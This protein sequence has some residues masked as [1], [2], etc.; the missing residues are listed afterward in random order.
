MRFS[1]VTPSF[2]SGKWLRSCIP[3]V[4]DQGSDVLLEHIVQDACSDDETAAFLPGDSR[5]TAIIE[6]DRGM[7]DAVNRGY[8]RAK[9][10]FLA[11]LNC[12]EQ[13]LPGAL[14]KVA[15]F[16][17]AH[18]TVD[19]VFADTLVVGKTGEYVCYRRA[20]PPRIAQSWIG[21]SL[22]ILTAATFVRRGVF[23][24]RGLWFDE[25]L[26]DIA[27]VVW[28]REVLRARVEMAVLRD[29]TSVFT[30]TGDNMNLKPNAQREKAELLASAPAWMRAG[31]P[32]ILAHNRLRRIWH[33]AY[34]CTPHDYAIYTAENPA[35]RTTFQ[36][37]APTP[38]WVHRE[39]NDP[40]S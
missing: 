16:F 33:G 15:K 19:V 28:V 30:D 7:Y 6:K 36:A 39:L 24:Q 4:A 5:V 26:K 40:A 29:F 32:L 27:D 21:N 13:Y 18:P 34:R 12:D 17:D 38:R 35:K 8:R 25:T 11:Y 20:I 2:R 31:R 9:G 22:N 1:I 3:S 14:K 23:H 37:P 10:E